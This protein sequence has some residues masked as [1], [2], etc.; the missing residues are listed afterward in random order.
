MVNLKELEAFYVKSQQ[1]HAFSAARIQRNSNGAKSMEFADGSWKMID[2]FYGGEPYGGCL[3][4]EYKGHVVWTQVYYGQVHNT[5]LP[6]DKVYDFL[7]LALREPP[8]ERPFRGPD[9]FMRNDLVYGN[10]VEGDFAVY[11]GKETILQN[12]EQIYWGAYL[13]GL[14]D[15]RAHDAD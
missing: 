11:S 1:P 14:V 4:I 10:A 9:S 2:T 3:A 15:Q 6:V 8:T 13:G 5:E 7:R 12:G